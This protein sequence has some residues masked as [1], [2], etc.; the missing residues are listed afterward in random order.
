[1]PGPASSVEEHS[2]CN[3]FLSS[4]DGGSNLAVGQVFSKR[5]NLLS[6]IGLTSRLRKMSEKSRNF[7]SEEFGNYYRRSPN[8]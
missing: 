6:I 5:P 2:L 1:M 7:E 4:S 3:M 8:L